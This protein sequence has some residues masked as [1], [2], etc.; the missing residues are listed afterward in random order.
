ML[1]EEKDTE[2]K[3]EGAEISEKDPNA[4]AAAAAAA[5]AAP[6]RPLTAQIAAL[7]KKNAAIKKELE[8]E[9]QKVERAHNFILEM[10]TQPKNPQTLKRV[11]SGR[12]A[13]AV[14]N[15]TA[16][17]N[18]DEGKEEED[19]SRQGVLSQNRYVTKIKYLRYNFFGQSEV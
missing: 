6:Q 16:G 8:Q 13:S 19:M 11:F 4:G 18:A 1:Q 3:Q 12:K 14:N 7:K 5:A 15:S 2:S 9:R 10:Q 17:T